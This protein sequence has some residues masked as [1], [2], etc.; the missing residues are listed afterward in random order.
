MV[1]DKWMLKAQIA[2]FHLY[3]FM[4]FY[5]DYPSSYGGKGLFVVVCYKFSEDNP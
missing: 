1:K 3:N 4:H 2:L 5:I